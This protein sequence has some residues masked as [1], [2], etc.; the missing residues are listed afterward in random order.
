MPHG[1]PRRVLFGGASSG[2]IRCARQRL[3]FALQLDRI[4]LLFD[5]HTPRYFSGE[6]AP[7]SSPTCHSQVAQYRGE[8]RLSYQA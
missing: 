1:S 3:P 2:C 5:S 6:L 4:R 7:A 8:L